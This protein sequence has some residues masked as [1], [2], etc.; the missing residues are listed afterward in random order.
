MLRARGSCSRT[1]INSGKV[2]HGGQTFIDIKPQDE[3]EGK[4]KENGSCL[5]G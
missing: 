4:T 2:I 3:G 5:I 1:E